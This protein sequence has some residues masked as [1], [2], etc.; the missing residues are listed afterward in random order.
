MTKG[1]TTWLYVKHYHKGDG[2][3]STSRS[4]PCSEY[5]APALT[6]VPLRLQ[7]NRLASYCTTHCQ[8]AVIFNPK[9]VQ[10]LSL[11]LAWRSL[12]LQE[13]NLP[14][15]VL[16]IIAN[17][18]EVVLIEAGLS[19]RRV[20]SSESSIARN[21]RRS[22]FADAVVAPFRLMDFSSLAEQSSYWSVLVAWV[23]W[24]KLPTSTHIL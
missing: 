11:D 13:V 9:S 20:E 16:N 19:F 7:V 6:L 4:L 24:K 17:K 8:T 2:D 12:S 14:Q 23:A 1:R 22:L 21:R 15:N 5:T 10:W 3:E 18:Q